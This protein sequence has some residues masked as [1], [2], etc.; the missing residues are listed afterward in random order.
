MICDNP[1]EGVPVLGACCEG[2]QVPD[3]CFIDGI[4]EIRSFSRGE[5]FGAF[6]LRPDVR[7]GPT[8]VRIP[9]AGADA[10]ETSVDDIEY[11]PDIGYIPP[12]SECGKMIAVQQY[13]ADGSVIFEGGQSVGCG[14]VERNVFGRTRC[15]VVCTVSAIPR[16]PAT[17]LFE[18]MRLHHEAVG[19][20]ISIPTTGP[21]WAACTDSGSYP[22]KI[23][24]VTINITPINIVY[25][26]P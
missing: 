13:R 1:A 18:G 22:E 16:P 26:A 23:E 21:D 20:E 7:G 5:S 4:D 8:S 15:Q 25:A 3:N 17:F 10:V 14:Y 6:T 11:E 12:R 24:D 9:I 19:I 2:T